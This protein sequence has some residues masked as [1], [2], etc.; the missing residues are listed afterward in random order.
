MSTDPAGAA[1]RVPV[2]VALFGFGQVGRRAA[3]LLA[4]RAGVEV[5]SLISRSLAGRP[6]RDV[7]PDLPEGLVIAADAERAFAETKPHVVL[8]A[9]APRLAEV[10]DQLTLAVRA[11][12]HVISS[13]E[14]LAYPWVVHRD[15]AEALDREARRFGVSL[16][17]TGV[18]PGF[19]FDALVLEA[20]GPRWN[21]TAISVSRVTDAS[22]FGPAVRGR[23]G[24]G[25]T[26]AEFD[27]MAAA[28]NVAGHVGF[29]ESMDLIA[30]AFGASVETFEES[31]K[32]LIADRDQAGVTAGLTVGFVQ[33]ALGTSGGRLRFDFRLSLNLWPQAVGLE[34]IDSINVEDGGAA[35]EVQVRPAS[36]PLETAA[37]QMVN[38]IP[39]IMVAGPGL[40]TR[41]DMRGPTPWLSFPKVAGWG[42]TGT[43]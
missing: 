14:E 13:C 41:L 21:P 2:R 16:L 30:A 31:I 37:A 12:C 43:Q 19:V 42:R 17:G 26:P 20:L 9:T 32:P 25:L 28:G 34:V 39:H 10:F 7:V 15:M 36:L 8:H 1:N 18:N 27:A 38:A 24:I 33:R 29:R 23:L 6:A 22:S 5:V 35:Y 11:G 40:R 3:T 4:R